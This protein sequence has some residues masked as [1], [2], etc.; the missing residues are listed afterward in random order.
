MSQEQ[1]DKSCL[2]HMFS[3]EAHVHVHM[4]NKEVHVHVH[5][6][7]KEVHVHGRLHVQHVLHVF[8]PDF[9]GFPSSSACIFSP[10]TSNKQLA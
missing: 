10:G 5:M 1:S 9:P 4:F 8:S 2:G 6:F 7:N 3:E